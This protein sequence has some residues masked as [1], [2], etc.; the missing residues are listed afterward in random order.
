MKIMSGRINM[1]Q[2]Q[3]TALIN[4]QVAAALAAAQAGATC[5]HFQEL[6]GLSSKHIQWHGR[7]SGTTPLV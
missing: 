1:T 2:A 5:L 3:L 6:H 7:S 4:E